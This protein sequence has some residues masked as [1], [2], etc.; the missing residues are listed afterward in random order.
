MEDWEQLMLMSCSNHHII[1]N[2]AFSWW[3]AYLNSSSD[4]IVVYPKQWFGAANSDKS[5]KDLFPP[6][7]ICV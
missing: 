1:A 4:K 6:Q 7:W 3:G 5:T 2:S